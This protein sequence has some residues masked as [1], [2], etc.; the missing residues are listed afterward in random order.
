[1]REGLSGRS[2]ATTPA[3]ERRLDKTLERLHPAAT[4][5]M[6]GAAALNGQ[7]PSPTFS[8]VLAQL[9]DA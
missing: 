7:A 9:S 8:S 1:M 6:T 3:E 4:L 2:R 5:A